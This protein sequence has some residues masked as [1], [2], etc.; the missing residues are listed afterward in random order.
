MI[1][2]EYLFKISLMGNPLK[3]IITAIGQLTGNTSSDWV[4]S[5]VGGIINTTGV[6]VMTH[7]IWVDSQMVKLVLS[8][9]H[10]ADFFEKLRPTFYRGASAGIIF[11]DKGDRASFEA[12][13]Y[14]YAEFKSIITNPSIPMVLIGFQTDFED[15]T[16]TEGQIASS[17][18]G[19]K[20][21]TITPKTKEGIAHICTQLVR[22]V[23]TEPL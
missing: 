6:D 20:Y 12:V 23:Q 14:W 18:L 15:V 9:I 11:F 22:E 16:D 17:K 1:S 21:I 10:P 7:R 2:N 4:K 8:L 19:L 5:V 13:N 3:Q